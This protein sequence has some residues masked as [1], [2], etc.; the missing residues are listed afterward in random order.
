[1]NSGLQ[2]DLFLLLSRSSTSY[3]I[4]V[5][6]RS[7]TSYH[8]LIWISLPQNVLFDAYNPGVFINSS[9]FHS[10]VP[11]VGDKLYHHS[12]WYYQ[13]A[14]LLSCQHYGETVKFT[15]SSAHHYSLLYYDFVPKSTSSVLVLT[16]VYDNPC[17]GIADC[18]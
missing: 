16:L 9:P 8:T 3:L 17:P 7:S 5:E 6:I 13:P 12:S 2:S 18:N 1:M 4:Q 15:P 10:E 14:R 11:G